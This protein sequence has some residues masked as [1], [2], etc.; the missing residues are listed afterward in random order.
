MREKVF[1]EGVHNRVLTS[2]LDRIKADIKIYFGKNSKYRFDDIFICAIY[3]S[4]SNTFIESAIDELKLVRDKIPSADRVLDRVGNKDWKELISDFNKLNS[5]LLKR[6]N[7]KHNDKKFDVG[8]DYTKVPRYK[9]NKIKGKRKRADLKKTVKGKSKNGTH[10]SH[11]FCT[12]DIIKEE[13]MFTLGVEPVFSDSKKSE[14][15]E[16]VIKYANEHIKIG[17]IFCDKEFFTTEILHTFIK[18][19][20]DFVVAVPKNKKVK[21]IIEQMKLRG[22]SI[23]WTDYVLNNKELSVKFTLVIIDKYKIGEIEDPNYKTRFFAYATNISLNNDLAYSLSQE[24]RLRWGEET[25]YRLEKGFRANTKSLNY[26]VR[27]FLFI[28]SLILSNIWIFINK[29]SDDFK[30][31]LEF[32]GGYIKAH[33]LRFIIMI[34]ILNIGSPSFECG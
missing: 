21:Q 27:C 1:E 24:F 26:K 28:L 20:V 31:T 16:K 12:I 14:V 29:V 3:A 19:G 13:D 11:S 30:P 23:Y 6:F 22:D 34:A 4:I 8:I 5:K 7:K 25:G 2:C 32:F 10:Y 33:T 18:I 15:V 9:K 17:K